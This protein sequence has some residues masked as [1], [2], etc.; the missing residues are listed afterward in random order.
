MTDNKSLSYLMDI[1]KNNKAEFSE[2]KSKIDSISTSVGDK[3]DPVKDDI[4]Q[5]VDDISTK[6]D[7]MKVTV[8]A[9]PAGIP[10]PPLLSMSAQSTENGIEVTYQAALVFGRSSNNFVIEDQDNIDQIFSTTKGVMIRYSNESYPL[11][12]KDGTL[13]TIDEDIYTLNTDTGVKTAKSKTYEIVGLTNSETYYISAFPYSSNY[14][15]QEAASSNHKNRVKCQWTGTKSTLTINVSRDVDY[16]T[17]GEYTITVTPT[18]GGEKVS[19]TQS[20]ESTIVFSGLEAGQY[21]LSFSSVSNFTKPNNQT[22]SLTAGHPVTKDIKYTIIKG[23][24]NYS[25]GEIDEIGKAGYADRIFSQG[26]TK[27]FTLTNGDTMTMELVAFNH[28]FSNSQKTARHPMTF[29]SKEVYNKA[30]AWDTNATGSTFKSYEVSNINKFFN[31]TI[32]PKIPEEITNIAKEIYRWEYDDK[33]SGSMHSRLF[34]APSATELFGKN[35]SYQNMYS[36][37]QREYNNGHNQ[38]P[39]YINESRRSKTCKGTSNFDY[40]TASPLDPVT[41]PN[42][43]VVFESSQN[44]YISCS[45]RDISVGGTLSVWRTTCICFCV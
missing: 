16:K 41:Y 12:P 31:N 3:L 24:S 44:G 42:K 40:W 37:G 28:N 33:T 17:L 38:F 29:V 14:V 2:I 18:G 19:K 21:T 11:T 23:L 6:V 15:Y 30:I 36:V 39:Y 27:T 22:I 34:W 25:W 8:D 45:D 9:S 4:S 5:L 26:D 13:A 43:E 1:D 32:I 20:G 35:T 10:A 7:D